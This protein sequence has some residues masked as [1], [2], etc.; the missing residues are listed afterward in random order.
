MVA[1]YIITGGP[2]SGKSTLIEGLRRKGYHC[3]SEISR[4]LIREQRMVPEGVLP[5][6]NLPA[7]ARL[8]CQA[9]AGQYEHALKRQGILFFDR[10]IPDI[11]GYL[12]AGGYR[13][14]QEYLDLHAACHYRRTVF[15]LPPWPEIFVNDA[16]RPQTYRESREL[17]RSLCAV[18]DR[19]GYELCELPKTTVEER[20][21][22]LSAI[23]G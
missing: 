3:Y 4:Q 17:Y 1:G 18:Y 14:P 21:R 12:E 9:M 16:E 10:G 19:L 22:F 7:F 13:V 8:A 5:W 6:K 2:G 15:V 23:T 20:V 11:F